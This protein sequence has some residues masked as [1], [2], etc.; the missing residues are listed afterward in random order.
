M[1]TQVASGVYRVDIG[2]DSEIVYVAGMPDDL[3]AFRDGRIFRQ[4]ASQQ[5]T[6]R[7]ADA[8]APQPLTAPMPGTVLKVLVEPGEH[9]E[10]GQTMIVLEA[11]KMELPL[12]AL[13]S[14]VV[15][16]V[17]CR[18]GELVQADATLVDF[19]SRP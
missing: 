15:A 10:K 1:V 18:E 19:G 17:R 5:P 14:A 6:A 13:D 12:R 8:G 9:V 2:G 3:W 7:T 4:R 16:A 11:M